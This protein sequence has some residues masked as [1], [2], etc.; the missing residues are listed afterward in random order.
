MRFG[1]VSARG[2]GGYLA[3]LYDDH[4]DTDLVAIA[5]RNPKAFDEGRKTW[6][7]DKCT[8]REYAEVGDMLREE[9]LDWV[10]VGTGDP[11]H[12]DVAV[13]VLQA[14]C[15][16]F[17]EKPMCLTMEHADE[18]CRVQQEKGVRIV[19][20]CEVRYTTPVVQFR[21]LLR[22]GAIGKLVLGQCIE[23]QARGHTYF[24]RPHRHKAF[25]SPPL[26]Q[27]GI[28]SV[29]LIYSLVE[30]DPVRVFAS[31]GLDFYGRD[32]DAVGRQCKDC[33]KAATCDFHLHSG[34]AIA[35]W[36]RKKI[37]K[38]EPPPAAPCVFDGSIDVDDN[39]L[40][41]LDFAN[42][43]RVSFADTYFAPEDKRE[44]TFHG[45]KGRATLRMTARPKVENVI[46]IHRMYED[47]P[48][49]I[50]IPK[51]EGGHGGG[52]PALRD[53]VVR[54]FRTGEDVSPD[55]RE[56]RM[57]VATI[58][59]ALKSMETGHAVDIPTFEAS[60]TIGRR[61]VGSGHA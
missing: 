31:G 59:M 10:L 47:E 29:D 16:A 19:V 37:S 60:S 4:P 14:G 55:G 42:G 54:S 18:L 15:N 49:I 57:G 7:L 33:D 22:K 46:E 40:L 3:T 52:D 61:G 23:T 58:L 45:T 41:L 56:A 32:P 30:A 1:V 26:L 20:G 12:Y 44:L 38:D 51:D 27:K 21:E 53:A 43:V 11:Q 28:H 6:G 36:K 48:E 39:G 17:I 13:Q 34:S 24:R 50:E 8:F 9:D 25:G 35:E 2:R 5:D